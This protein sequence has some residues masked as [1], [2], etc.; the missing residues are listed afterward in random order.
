M[1]AS[2]K[3]SRL[4]YFL[5]SEI[6]C[7]V[8]G[9]ISVSSGVT[10]EIKDG[11][12]A[13]K[14]WNTIHRARTLIAC[15]GRCESVFYSHFCSLPTL[16][17]FT[18]FPIFLWL[19]ISPTSIPEW[20]QSWKVSEVSGDNTSLIIC[21]HVSF[22]LRRQHKAIRTRES[23]GAKRK[24]N[25]IKLL[26]ELQ[27]SRMMF[28][29]FD[30]F[31]FCFIFFSCLVV[32]TETEKLS[33]SSQAIEKNSFQSGNIPCAIVSSINFQ[34]SSVLVEAFLCFHKL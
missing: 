20:V 11:R 9:D 4:F 6:L 16:A 8:F 5:R 17:H 33:I 24:K 1:T 13:A 23:G 31:P 7:D 32:R 27:A 12:T 25:L 26:A 29:Y 3:S 18:S 21:A 2:T 10:T 34:F 30:S 28:N 15:P 14:L 22:L 19:F